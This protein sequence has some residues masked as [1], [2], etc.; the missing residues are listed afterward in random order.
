MTDLT[1][2]QRVLLA[3]GHQEPDRVPFFLLVTMHGARELGVS[4]REYFSRPE[5][6]V[7]GQLRMRAR[8]RHDC[9]YSF[10]YAAVEVEAWGGEVLYRD[11]GPPNAG[12]PI[13]RKPVDIEHLHPPKIGEAACLTKVLT[14]QQMLKARV[15]DDAPIIGVVMS[16]FSLPVMQMGFDRYLE[17][18]YE[19][20]DLFDRLMQVNEEF[21]VA[22]ANAQLEAG[23]TAITYFDPVSSST[24]IPRELS[25]KTGLTIARRT[26]AR[27]KGPT[28][29]HMA[30]GRCLP[31][32]DDLLQT[33]A[34]VVGVSALE[35]LAAL[36]AVW[37]GKLSILGNL[38]AIEMRRWTPEQT[39][40]VVRDAI[41]TAGPGGG[42][43]L[44]DNHGEIPWQVPEDVLLAVSDAVHQWGRYP[45]D[46]ASEDAGQA[47][48][49]GL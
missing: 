4:I 7:E 6:V 27:I 33:G 8:Y 21:C 18:I 15:G 34:A 10:F 5:H 39:Q 9:L 43:I 19:Q 29:V 35:D 44:S 17:L 30:S 13:V 40:A 2:L 45:L 49:A 22:W 48:S 32:A 23:A 37:R 16:P 36:K 25:L 31:I 12:A 1:S 3:L 26:I 41:A 14:A 28:A 46:W 11:D 20:P 24:I 42:F 47:A 38:N